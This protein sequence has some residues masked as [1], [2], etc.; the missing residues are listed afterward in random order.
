[1]ADTC[2]VITF[3]KSKDCVFNAKKLKKLL[4]TYEWDFSGSKWD[5]KDNEIF[6]DGYSF[7]KS[8]YPSAVPE[9]IQSYVIF[10]EDGEKVSKDPSQMELEDWD[11][12]I[13]TVQAPRSLKDLSEAISPILKNGWIEFA[14]VANYKWKHVY[15]ESMRV[16]ADGKVTTRYSRSGSGTEPLND[17]KEYVPSNTDV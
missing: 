11:M 2:G 13:D 17:V 12:V 15:F 8:A 16:Y 4:N 7:E 14:C 9:M 10:S 3:S 6:L 5:Y 1:M